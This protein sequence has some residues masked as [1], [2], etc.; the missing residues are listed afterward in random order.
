MHK[1]SSFSKSSPTLDFGLFCLYNCRHNEDEVVSSSTFLNCLPNHRHTLC[2]AHSRRFPF[3]Q[4][5]CTH[6]PFTAWHGFFLSAWKNWW[7]YP[8]SKMFPVLALLLLTSTPEEI[9]LVLV[10]GIFFLKHFFIKII[11]Y[12]Q[13][14]FN[15]A[16]LITV[17]TIKINNY[18]ITS[19]ISPDPLLS[20]PLPSSCSDSWQPLIYFYDYWIC[21][22]WN[23]IEMNHSIC[24]LLSLVSFPLA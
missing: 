16:T 22:F 19:N 14:M 10:S 23:V 2:C 4:I 11:I 6:S 20:I 1:A 18:S 12:I 3:P 15:Y 9:R 21:P 24:S 17:T 5:G 8:H 13:M 7:T